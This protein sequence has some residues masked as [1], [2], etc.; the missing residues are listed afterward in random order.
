MFV[1]VRNPAVPPD[2]SKGFGGGA[3]SRDGRGR[4][5]K[6]RSRSSAVA[7]TI[8][9]YQQAVAPAPVRQAP[10]WRP[11]MNSWLASAKRRPSGRGAS[12]WI[13]NRSS[14]AAGS[15]DSAP[16]ETGPHAGAS[17]SKSGPTRKRLRKCAAI[18]AIEP[19]P[20]R[21]ARAGESGMVR[22]SQR[23]VA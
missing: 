21:T 17:R 9:E 2:G 11:P 20:R 19:S 16:A 10:G 3:T 15:A 22:Q 12:A 1:V 8:A 18:R 14:K 5:R 7:A 23:S 4:S 6:T 13:Q